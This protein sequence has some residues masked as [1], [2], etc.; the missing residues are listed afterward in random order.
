MDCYNER[1]FQ[2]GSSKNTNQSSWNG[3]VGV[4][5][6]ASVSKQN[7]DRNEETEKIINNHSQ[8]GNLFILNQEFIS[9]EKRKSIDLYTILFFEIMTASINFWGNDKDSISVSL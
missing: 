3:P 5:Q 2:E 8:I 9:G 6:I 1:S 4:D 7:I